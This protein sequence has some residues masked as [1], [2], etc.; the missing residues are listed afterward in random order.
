MTHEL[1]FAQCFF[2]INNYAL[3]SVDLL[4]L[5]CSTL[6][7]VLW[8]GRGTGGWLPP[9]P[10]N[11]RSPSAA[12][13]LGRRRKVWPRT[14]AW[15]FMCWQINKNKNGWLSTR[16]YNTFSKNIS[17]GQIRATIQQTLQW[18]TWGC[19]P[20]IFDRKQGNAITKVTFFDE[21]VSDLF[22]LCFKFCLTIWGSSGDHLGVI[23]GSS[24]D[25]PGV[26]RE[27]SGSHP[28]SFFRFFYNASPTFFKTGC[29]E[30]GWQDP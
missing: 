19:S 22:Q 13:I 30:T 16:I 20:P 17:L 5:L 3:A 7:R 8:R 1:V 12:Q 11:A 28:G 27:S 2:I 21:L 25:H 15:L 14:L 10:N 23:R 4:L 18:E 29:Q 26:I 9:S 24:G 6:K